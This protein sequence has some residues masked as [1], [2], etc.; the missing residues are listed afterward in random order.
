MKNDINL[1][2][3]VPRGRERNKMKIVQPPTYQIDRRVFYFYEGP[4]WS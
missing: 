1:L 2:N 3:P 4:I